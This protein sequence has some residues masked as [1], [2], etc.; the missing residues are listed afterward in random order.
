MTDKIKTYIDKVI[1]EVRAFIEADEPW[2]VPF[3]GK[4]SDIEVMDEYAKFINYDN[5]L[6]NHMKNLDF[7]IFT[8]NQAKMGISSNTPAGQ[9]TLNQLNSHIESLRY[10]RKALDDINN[11]HYLV[12]R[13]FDKGGGLYN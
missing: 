13:Y 2:E 9:K 11:G 6:T 3:N 12:A 7:L 10:L 8:L 1:R 5:I 4:L